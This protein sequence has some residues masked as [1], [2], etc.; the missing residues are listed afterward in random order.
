MIQAGQTQIAPPKASGNVKDPPFGTLGGII[1]AATEGGSDAPRRFLLTCGHVLAPPNLGQPAGVMQDA[2]TR[3]PLS[4]PG[5]ATNPLA[6]GIDVGIAELLV[7]ADPAIPGLGVPT[8]IAAPLEDDED[9][10]DGKG[11]PLTLFGARS[12]RTIASRLVA[13]VADGT[14]RYIDAAGSQRDVVFAKHHLILADG[15]QEG[16]SGAF[17]MA[18][19]QILGILIGFDLRQQ[20]LAVVAPIREVLKVAGKLAGV[21]LQPVQDF[22]EL[23]DDR[24]A[25]LE[26][27]AAVSP[28][29]PVPA[30]AGDSDVS[31]KAAVAPT[32]KADQSAIP[33]S[34][35][36]LMQAL[37]ILKFGKAELPNLAAVMA[38]ESSGFGF[39]PD[40][41]TKI[42][43]ERHK[44][45]KA[46]K[47][48]F[49]V[50]HS[51][52][53][54]PEAGGYLGGAA[55]HSRLNEALKLCKDAGVPEEAALSSAS[56]G[57]GQVM[58]FNHDSVG[59]AS[60]RAMVE[61]FA[62]GEAEQLFAMVRFIANK[63]NLRDALLQQ[64]WTTF[65]RGY[66]GAGFAA[67]GYHLKLAA[68]FGRA[69]AGKSPDVGVRRI[70][71]A[72]LYLGELTKSGQVDGF[73]GKRTEVAV[74]RWKQ[75]EGL[76]AAP[77]LTAAQ[78][79]MLLSA[80]GIG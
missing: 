68:A 79:V 62:T 43:F 7:P 80:A 61:A 48:M 8:G 47:G 11:V 4:A 46:T 76:D 5:L 60:S 54:N 26:A 25:L 66:N 56:W 17:V 41:R 70:Q 30:P 45:H 77:S 28:P 37:G 42:L 10:L 13:N 49:S 39:L 44:F 18:G 52:L 59:F 16:D 1:E 73:Q 78:V 72:L 69:T 34:D 29:A 9:S 15:M 22:P 64:D 3:M 2:E 67:Q 12:R 35:S 23:L 31:A 14:V 63:K 33:Y 20:H 19:G 24:P 53:S 50:D 65:A 40:R 27:D 75:R 74:Q 71:A 38:V 55:E 57:L 36:D 58:G 32:S 51:G 21:A 6:D